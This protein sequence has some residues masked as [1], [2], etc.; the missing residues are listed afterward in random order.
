MKLKALLLACCLAGAAQ[1]DTLDA[2]RAAF[3]GDARAWPQAWAQL[4]PEA[5]GGSAAAAYYLGL[6]YR[7]GMGVARDSRLAA[8]W[9]GVAAQG[10]VAAAMFTLSNMLREG[11]GVA[12][13]EAGA[14]RWLEAA[15]ASDYPE[16]LQELAMQE[17]DAVRAAQLMKQA[18]HAMQHRKD[19]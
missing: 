1:A 11:E 4:Q 16:A 12:R 5:R 9:L 8:H 7:N 14:R 3:R 10:G 17:S 15:A 6:M 13:D 19:P 18:A 2:A